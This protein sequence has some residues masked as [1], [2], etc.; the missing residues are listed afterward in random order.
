[1]TTIIADLKNKRIY[2]DKCASQEKDSTMVHTLITKVGITYQPRLTSG[3]GKARIVLDAISR[4]DN[5]PI[6]VP[7]IYDED[8]N[9]TMVIEMSGK[10]ETANT[11]LYTLMG[12]KKFLFFKKHYWMR[13][14]ITGNS[15]YEC[16]GS[17]R[18]Y[19]EG[20]LATGCTPEEAIIAAGKCD[21]YTGLGVDM[22]ELD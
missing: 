3:C 17:G 10:K 5:S 15:G 19:A 13:T 14:L 7:K 12:K 2:S 20:A 8:S 4:V 1:M 22:V 16:L 18:K 11:Y 21:N 6:P 9:G